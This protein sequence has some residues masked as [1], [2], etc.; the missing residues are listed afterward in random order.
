MD[1]IDLDEC[2]LNALNFFINSPLLEFN[3]NLYKRPVII[4][5][6]NAEIT[7]K[8]IFEDMNAIFA[9]ESNYLKKIESSSNID[10]CIIIS[11]S[12]GK[13]APLIAKELKKRDISIT[14]L[15]N[16][17][18]A[19]AKEYVNNV[20]IFPKNSE[21]Y[22]YNVST[23]L[24]MILSKTKENPKEILSLIKK[25]EDNI[26]SNLKEYDSFFIIIPEEF[27]NIREMFLTKFDELFGSKIS[28]RVFTSEQTKHAKT[29]VPSEKE[30]FIS[31]G[32]VNELYGKNKLNISLTEN[33][34][35]AELLAL[36]YYVI[37]NIQKQNEPYFKNNI[38]T[39]V[40][41]ASELFNQKIDL[42]I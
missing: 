17:P 30:L 5:S 13:H 18:N 31:F 33:V 29:I 28:G 22:T 41:N 34:N 6:G 7:G 15:T 26:P 20:Y 36:G 4:G 24:G 10:G 19:I 12:G 42:I 25:I 1:L 38:S 23:Y 40:K 16:N 2:V 3:F 21:P 8:I 27:E 11:S 39:Y 35:Y 9:N 32:Y 37:G 14:L